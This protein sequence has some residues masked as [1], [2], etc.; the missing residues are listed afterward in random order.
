MIQAIIFDYGNVLSHTLDRQPRALWEHKLGLAP[1]AL[2]R[3]VHNDHSW[4]EVQCGRLSVDAYWNEV[5]QTLNLTPQGV[6]ALRA[7]FYRGDRRNDGLVAHIDQLRA[8]GLRTAILSNF[9]T[10]LRT[11]LAQQALPHRFN[12]IVISAEIGIMKPATAAYRAV[13][14]RLALVPE[15]CVF[16]DDLA[17]NVEAAQAMGMQG[18][19]FRDNRSCFAALER[20]LPRCGS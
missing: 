3:T 1:G 17:A 11:M 14:D 10:E 2:Q 20:L 15:C 7:D 9:S 4:V 12:A 18:I 5:G 6:A 19:V 13:L 16:I 8:T